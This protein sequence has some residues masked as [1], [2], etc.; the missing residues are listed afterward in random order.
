MAEVAAGRSP[1]RVLVVTVAHR[2]DDARILHR[3]IDALVTSGAEVTYIAPAPV[4]DVPGVRRLVVPRAVGRHRVHSWWQ[5]VRSAR[6][7]RRSVDLV[8]VHDLELVVPVRLAVPGTLVV[9]DV[10]EDL[11]ASVGDREWIP[12]SVRPFAGTA[13]ALL[14]RLAAWRI[15]LILAETSY[16]D[17]LGDWPVVPN[18]TA[19]PVA[20]APYSPSALPRLVYVGRLSDPRGLEQMIELGRR[21]RGIC[22]VELIGAVDADAAAALSDAVD[23]GDVEW[24]EYLPNPVAMSRVEGALVGLSLLRPLPNY[25]G[26]MPTKVY[27]Y[28]ARGVPVISTPLPLA[29]DVLERSGAGFVVGYDDVDAVAEAVERLRSDPGLRER[30]GRLGH[31]FVGVDHNWNRDGTSFVEVLATWSLEHRSKRS[32]WSRSWMT[33]RVVDDDRS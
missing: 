27:E 19:V 28:L 16:R 13:V 7:V 12:T 24:R 18:S 21:L 11:A 8:L 29:V 30:L 20:L 25:V 10:H 5:A 31:D 17:R 2:G 1:L 23:A 4:T 9:W 32:W 15:K 6:S 22:V 3:Q 26:S 14:E 33:S